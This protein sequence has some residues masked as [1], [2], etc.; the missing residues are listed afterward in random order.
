[1]NER[2]ATVAINWW[3]HQGHIA[4]KKNDTAR[5]TKKNKKKELLSA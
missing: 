2:I 3:Y 5:E 4:K 1:M